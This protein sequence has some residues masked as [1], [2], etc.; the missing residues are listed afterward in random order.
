MNGVLPKESFPLLLKRLFNGNLVAGFRGTGIY[1]L[2]MEQVLKRLPPDESSTQSI[3]ER[4]GES[5]TDLLKQNLCTDK[6]P[7]RQKRGPK[8]PS[9]KPISSRDIETLLFLEPEYFAE[10]PGTETSSDSEV[11]DIDK[12]LISSHEFPP[13]DDVDEIDWEGCDRCDNWYHTFCLDGEEAKF[14]KVFGV[15]C[16]AS[17]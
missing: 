1:P 8:V 7:V 16:G 4:F 2:D 10:A 5:V 3:S 12:C 9:G 13:C 11:N 17:V 15:L 6:A 14:V